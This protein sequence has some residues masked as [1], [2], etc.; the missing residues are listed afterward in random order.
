MQTLHR[1]VAAITGAGSGIGRGVAREL[2]HQ[3]S[4]LALSDADDDGLA[5]TV[6]LIEQSAGL[7]GNVKVTSTR[8]D[9][10]ECDAVE[11]WAMSTV[12]EF[13]HVNLIFNNAGLRW[14]PTSVQ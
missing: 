4:H 2:A 1:K 7:S 8:I 9:V 10:T 13:G 6:A 5:E 12:E 11:A 14:R 3:G